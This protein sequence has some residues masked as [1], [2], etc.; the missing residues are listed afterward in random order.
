MRLSSKDQV[1]NAVDVGVNNGGA[2]KLN[3]S[4]ARGIE[5]AKQS[6]QVDANLK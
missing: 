2:D 5:N 3:G 6:E 4:K 1:K